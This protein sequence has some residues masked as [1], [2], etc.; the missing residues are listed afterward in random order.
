MNATESSLA[1]TTKSLRLFWVLTLIGSL[2][3]LGAALAVTSA[4]RVLRS[5]SDASPA[6]RLVATALGNHAQPQVQVCTGSFLWNTARLGTCF[7]NLPAEANV[8]LRNVRAADVSLFRLDPFRG[9]NENRLLFSK[10]DETLNHGGWEKIVSVAKRDV[11]I[12]VFMKK[13]LD[14]MRE[15]ELCVVFLSDREE[16]VVATVRTNLEEM[17]AGLSGFV[18]WKG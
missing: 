18:H 2:P 11:A 17:A 1:A 4:A 9:R 12:L 5:S 3:F 6:A 16:L 7:A 14:S 15:A 13:Q 10:I 8:V